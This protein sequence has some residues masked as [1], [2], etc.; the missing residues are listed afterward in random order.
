MTSGYPKGN[1]QVTIQ[2]SNSVLLFFFF[3]PQMESGN[4]WSQ[5][6]SQ[7]ETNLVQV[8]TE[9]HL[10]WIRSNVR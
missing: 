2:G 3:F 6:R 1:S 10:N 8:W 7:L 5:T 9:S 4:H